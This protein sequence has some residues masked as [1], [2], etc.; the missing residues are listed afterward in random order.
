MSLFSLPLV[1]FFWP[2]L[3]LSS[4][5]S[6]NSPSQPSVNC[7]KHCLQNSLFLYSYYICLSQSR[8]LF[9]LLRTL[10][11]TSTGPILSCVRRLRPDLS[12]SKIWDGF[13]L[14]ISPGHLKVLQLLNSTGKGTS[15]LHSHGGP[16]D[17]SIRLT[18]CRYCA[19]SNKD[20]VE[21][22]LSE[23]KAIY[24]SFLD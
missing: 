7:C 24:M 6:T 15:S 10:T 17:I 3:R 11:S 9:F 19:H 5:L 20:Y 22:L 8:R 23:D 1:S 12:I 4:H 16:K 14:T 21:Y 2:S 18:A 13:P